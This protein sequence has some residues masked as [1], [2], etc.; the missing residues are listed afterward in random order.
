MAIRKVQVCISL[1]SKLLEAAK[2][3]FGNV[4]KAINDYFTGVL[5]DADTELLDKVD[6]LIKEA[7]FVS[8]SLQDIRSKLMT[9]RSRIEIGIKEHDE[10]LTAMF[11]SNTAVNALSPMDLDN[12]DLLLA[13]VDAERAKGNRISMVDILNYHKVKAKREGNANE[14]MPVP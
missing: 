10:K 9:E 5:K 11:A 6:L 1:D 13:I 4:S 8:L 14:N 3:K 12:T 7:D 2:A